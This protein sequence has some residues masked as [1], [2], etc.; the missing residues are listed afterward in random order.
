MNGIRLKISWQNRVSAKDRIDFIPIDNYGKSRTK[1]QFWHIFEYPFCKFRNQTQKIKQHRHTVQF[2]YHHKGHPIL[3][4]D[5]WNWT[6]HCMRYVTVVRKSIKKT[7]I[8]PTTTHS[9]FYR[10]KEEKEN[11]N[12]SAARI[13]VNNGVSV[14]VVFTFHL[15]RFGRECSLFWLHLLF[16]L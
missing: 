8:A 3:N 7:R 1:S 6:K 4:L 2:F 13:R 5:H 12:K 15:Q 10:T 9:S 14:S 11:Q 16:E